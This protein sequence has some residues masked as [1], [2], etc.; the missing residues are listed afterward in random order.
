LGRLFDRVTTAFEARFLEGGITAT[1]GAKR[2][3]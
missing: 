3:R 1:I 2:L